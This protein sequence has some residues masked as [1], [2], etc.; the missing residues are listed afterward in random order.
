MDNFLSELPDYYDQRLNRRRDLSDFNMMLIHSPIKTRPVF[1]YP[2]VPIISQLKYSLG[3][4][5]HFNLFFP[6]VQPAS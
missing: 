1:F 3:I 6:Q 4:L 5:M 2:K